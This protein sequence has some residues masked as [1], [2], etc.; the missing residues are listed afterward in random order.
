MLDCVLVASLVVDVVCVF[1]FGSLWISNLF[2][3]VRDVWVVSTVKGARG[4]LQVI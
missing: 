4:K 2:R 3:S 1:G